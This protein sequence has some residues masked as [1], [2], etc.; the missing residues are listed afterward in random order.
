M[1]KDSVERLLRDEGVTFQELDH[2][3]RQCKQSL[4]E[5]FQVFHNKTDALNSKDLQLFLNLA[6]VSGEVE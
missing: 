3:Y 2:L 1:N 6:Q 4:N 5:F